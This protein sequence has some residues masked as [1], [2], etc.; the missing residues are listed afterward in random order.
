MSQK[1]NDCIVVIPTHKATMTPEDERS[2]RNTLD[3]L[4]NWD[5]ALFLPHDVSHEHY[6]AI[7]MKD[8]SQFKIITAR[9]GWMGSIEKYNDMALSPEFYQLFKEYKYILICH[10]DAW[11]FRDEL[12]KWIA[13]GYDYIGAPWFLSREE[14]YVPL[15]KL[16]C[17]QGGNGGFSLR[18]VDK[19]I[20]LL[21]K[22]RRVL[23][24]ALFLK[25][26][27]FLLKNKKINFLRIYIR[28]CREILQN[29]VTFQKKYN[30]Y[31]DALLSVFYSLLDK[32][33]YVAPPEE[34]IFFATEVYSE[35]IFNSKLKWQLPFAIH[36]YDKYL[37][38]INSIDKY[39]NDANRNCYTKNL[40]RHGDTQRQQN[41]NPPMVTVVT[42]T[43]NI[44]KAGRIE[45]FKQCIQSVHEQTYNNIE[46]V[47]IDGA[48]TDGTLELIQEY[49]DKGWCVCYSEKDDGVWDAMHKGHQRAKG[50]FVNYMNSDDYFCKTDAIEIAVNS[51][52][53]ENADWFFS[54]GIIVRKDGTSY[55]FPTSL[56][57]VFSCMGILHQT[58]FVRTDILRGMNPFLSNHVTKEN[59]LMMLLCINNIKYA[60]S[61]ES[62]VCYREGGFST[63]EY[64]NSNLS[65][66][67]NDFAK[68]FYDSIGR[69]WGM[70][71][72]ECL[73]MFAWECFGLK[74]VAY[75]YRLSKKL[76]IR[77]LRFAFRMKLAR[78]VYDNRNIGRLLLRELGRLCKPRR[79]D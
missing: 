15:E 62:L 5:I 63:E 36:G 30:V 57:G 24:I 74:G 61:K 38:S 1:S 78:Y 52:V 50:Q 69:F 47:I 26:F 34:A 58:V 60:S 53:T 12:Q 8:E 64:G 75:S 10:L 37:M 59:Y 23:N 45:T 11:V 2:F 21:S 43:H 20:E 17:P 48:S 51:L 44:I 13:K 33:F 22:Q 72:D 42:A 28:S 41:N 66:T 16:M 14:N 6:D 56:Y 3:V 31:E 39:R 76:R 25:G 70:T 35:E 27:L 67:K 54:E 29:V 49:V 40:Y 19:M 9:P 55:S 77:G 73:S 71:E 7:R 79:L 68:Y 46:H 18:K 4:H 65:R 32:T